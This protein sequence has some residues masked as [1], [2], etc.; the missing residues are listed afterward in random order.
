MTNIAGVAEK[1]SA[2]SI[3][4]TPGVKLVH[5][6]AIARGE[7]SE[8]QQ[9]AREGEEAEDDDWEEVE[10]GKGLAHYNSLEM[11][12]IKGLKR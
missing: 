6:L 2:T 4:A 12:R 5:E 7:R 10:V 3:D 9:D 8:A 1:L 11:N